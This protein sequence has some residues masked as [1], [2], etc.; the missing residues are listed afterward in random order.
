MAN[1]RIIKRKTVWVG[2]KALS[3]QKNK[4]FNFNEKLLDHLYHCQGHGF[5]VQDCC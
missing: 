1:H 4:K 5:F 2:L 3:W